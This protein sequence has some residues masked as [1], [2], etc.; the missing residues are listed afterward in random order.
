MG[1]ISYSLYIWQQCFFP[2][3]DVA[4]PLHVLQRWPL[5]VPAAIAC[6]A[7]SYYV[8]ERPAIRLGHRLAPPVAEGRRDLSQH[9]RQSIEAVAA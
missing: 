9:A 7:A 2:P 5:G 4:A 8:V 6:A 1:R 3:A